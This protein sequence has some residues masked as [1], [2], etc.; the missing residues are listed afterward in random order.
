[1]E[2]FCFVFLLVTLEFQTHVTL[3]MTAHARRLIEV[4]CPS[5]TGPSA[6]VGKGCV[7][8]GGGGCSDL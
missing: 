4:W 5:F 3:A 2:R 1:M 6:E 8:G 7:A